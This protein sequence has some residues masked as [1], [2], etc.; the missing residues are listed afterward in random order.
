MEYI[1]KSVE[2]HFKDKINWKTKIGILDIFL[3][4]FDAIETLHK[5]GKAVHRDI[6]PDNFRMQDGKIKMI[7]FGL[8]TYYL[9]SKG[10]HYPQQNMKNE[11]LGTLNTGSTKAM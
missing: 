8:T 3:Q 7:D 4:M 6:K 2:E 9:D 11:F 5:L 10:I 1:N